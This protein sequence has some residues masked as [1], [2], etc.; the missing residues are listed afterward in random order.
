MLNQG[1]DPAG[2]SVSNADTS[3]PSTS[4]A[5]EVYLS[6]TNGSGTAMGPNE[7]QIDS[8][9]G[10]PSAVWAYSGHSAAGVQGYV[11]KVSGGYDAMV[12]IPWSD[13]GAQ[14]GIGRIIGIDP[15][16]DAY[17]DG[18]TQN[19]ALAWGQLGSSEQNP[20]IWGQAKL[21]K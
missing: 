18:S 3:T 14:R 1:K 8:P 13:I 6:A 4:D 17:S 9:I 5:M 20:S 7:T 2:F 21:V 10:Q 16:A 11:R 12:A 15:A 19:Q